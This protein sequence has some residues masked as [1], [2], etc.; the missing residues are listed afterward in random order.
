D[1]FFLV[2]LGRFFVVHCHLGMLMRRRATLLPITAYRDTCQHLPRRGQFGMIKVSLETQMAETAASSIGFLGGGKM[3]TWLP[4]A[5]VAAGLVGEIHASDPL[6]EARQ[7]FTTQTGV[8]AR[9]DNLE[10]VRRGD[11]LILAVKPQ[12]L[13]ALLTQIRPALTDR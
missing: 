8:T 9:A 4:R 11:V 10:V 1:G 2:H 12:V 13:P 7:N 5:G 6:P 3:P